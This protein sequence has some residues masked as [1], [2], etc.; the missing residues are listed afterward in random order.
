MAKKRF[1]DLP[2]VIED[3]KNGLL[4]KQVAWKYNVSEQ[5]ARNW[6]KEFFEKVLVVKKILSDPNQLKLPF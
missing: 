4:P 3:F 2:K 5:V 6:R 1:C